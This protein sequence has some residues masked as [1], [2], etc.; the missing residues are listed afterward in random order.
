VFTAHSKKPKLKP[1]SIGSSGVEV[2]ASAAGN[3]LKRLLIHSQLQH[4]IRKE[5]HTGKL[6]Y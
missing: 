3:A 1:D 5:Y 6:L 2:H 4:C